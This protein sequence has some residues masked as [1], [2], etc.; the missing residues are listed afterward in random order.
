[1][2]DTVGRGTRTLVLVAALAIALLLQLGAG[3]LVTLPVA[4]LR[5]AVGAALLLVGVG[6]G[7]QL[8]ALLRTA[9]EHGGSATA[10]WAV[11]AAASVAGSAL[12][13]PLALLGGTL[14]VTLV[15]A[16]CYAL[17][18]ARR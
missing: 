7:G 15:G 16:G 11:N 5:L 4:G 6:L 14:A 3:G 1:G 13:A 17:V 10:L 2:R 12:A 8:P 18:A 9:E